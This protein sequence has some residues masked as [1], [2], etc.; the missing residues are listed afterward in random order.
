MGA[1]LYIAGVCDASLVKHLF[2]YPSTSFKAVEILGRAWTLG[3]VHMHESIDQSC[4]L[5]A[6]PSVHPLLKEL[7]KVGQSKLNR[8]EMGFLTL[9]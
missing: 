1:V 8:R 7:G 6:L 2:M 4:S 5:A 9:H 3:L